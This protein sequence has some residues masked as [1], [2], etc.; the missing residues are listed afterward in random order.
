MKDYDQKQTISKP[1]NMKKSIKLLILLTLFLISGIGNA[2]VQMNFNFDTPYGS[3]TTVGKYAV[4]N[5]AKIYYEEYGKGEP[6][7]LI[8]GVNGDIKTMG[9]QIDYFKTKYRVIIADSRG[10]GKSELKTDSLTYDQITS[11]W[12]GLANTLKLDSLNVV[13]YSDGGIVGLKMGISGKLK[14]KKIV[15]VAANLRPDSTAINSWAVKFLINERKMVKSKIQE[16]DT[17]RN[18]NL[19]KQLIGLNADQPNI[20]TKDLSKIKAK[21]LIIAGDKDIIKNEH[22]VE[23][24][25]N[26]PKA[27]L[28]IMPGETHFTFASNPELLNAIVNTFLSKPFKRPDSDFTKW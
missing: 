10:Q 28:C 17:S 27:Q 15:A 22:S 18:W 4:I 2:Q 9:N 25:E 7:L 12:E 20:P 23:I 26:I 5:G 3:N 11:D 19:E 21:V 24:F 14:I 16:K 13:G 6:M 8:H 1:I